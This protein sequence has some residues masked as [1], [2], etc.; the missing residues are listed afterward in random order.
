VCDGIQYPANNNALKLALGSGRHRVNVAAAM[1]E[2]TCDVA[3]FEAGD[4][5]SSVTY[6]SNEFMVINHS[7]FNHA[8]PDAAYLTQ[9]TDNYNMN[10][11]WTHIDGTQSYQLNINKNT[12]D[13]PQAVNADIYATANQHTVLDVYDIP[14]KSYTPY[15]GFGAYTYSV[16]YQ[17]NGHLSNPIPYSSSSR[18]T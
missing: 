2:D 14:T 13:Y 6:S 5:I 1:I 18:S 17:L 15:T 16:Q 11:R 3:A 7:Q 4:L 12:V 10:V 9:Q 8:N